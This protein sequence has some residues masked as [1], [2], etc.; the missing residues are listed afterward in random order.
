MGDRYRIVLRKLKSCGF[1]PL[2]RGDDSV[3]AGQLYDNLWSMFGLGRAARARLAKKN[4]RDAQ[5]CIK[6]VTVT[7]YAW[8]ELVKAAFYAHRYHAKFW[9]HLRRRHNGS[10]AVALWTLDSEPSD[11]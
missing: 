6:G 4:G 10:M 11:V 1:K 2:P 9:K 7:D 8:T 5:G 3:K